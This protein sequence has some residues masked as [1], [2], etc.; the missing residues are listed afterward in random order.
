[1]KKRDLKQMII[2]LRKENKE[3]STTIH[4]LRRA[5]KTIAEKQ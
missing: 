2:G 5:H 3:L 1:M 4:N